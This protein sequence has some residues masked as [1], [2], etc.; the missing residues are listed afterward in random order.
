MLRLLA[1]LGLTLSFQ[2]GALARCAPPRDAEI[3]AAGGAVV[4][5]RIIEV[6]AN[7]PGANH[8]A[9]ALLQVTERRSGQS[10][11]VVRLVAADAGLY[12]PQFAVGQTITFA[13]GHPFG[14]SA[15]TMCDAR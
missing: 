6:G 1:A 5:G 11:A 10:P 7:A 9:S 4:S 8:A 15:V 3:V 14:E 12:T 2:G 13:V